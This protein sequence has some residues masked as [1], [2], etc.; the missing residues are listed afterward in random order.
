MIIRPSIE[1]DKVTDKGTVRNKD[2]VTD[3]DMITET[4]AITARSKNG[5]VAKS[6][7]S[8]YLERSFS[9]ME[10]KILNKFWATVIK[11]LNTG[12]ANAYRTTFVKDV[13]MKSIAVFYFFKEF[14]Y[15]SL[16]FSIH[17]YVRL[18]LSLSLSCY[19]SRMV[20]SWVI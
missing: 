4:V 1:L 3:K 9:N 16:F 18:Y 7:L 14:F 6:E 10:L 12:F 11:S 20:V 5:K 17:R 2:R 19:F 15:F 13:L 8:L